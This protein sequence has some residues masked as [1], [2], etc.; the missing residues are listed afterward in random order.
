MSIYM[1]M[2]LIYELCVL[3]SVASCFVWIVRHG[4]TAKKRTIVIFFVCRALPGEN[5]KTSTAL[6]QSANEVSRA[7]HDIEEDIVARAAAPSAAAR[8]GSTAALRRGTESSSS[9][10][11]A[12]LSAR[13]VSM[14]G[15]T[16]M[17]TTVALS[18]QAAH[19]R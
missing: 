5:M 8:I 14:S 2:C 1:Y 6:L 19:S 10:T 13:S 4:Q 18:E 12:S 16:F 11:L 17:C 3:R 7:A 15:A 9:P